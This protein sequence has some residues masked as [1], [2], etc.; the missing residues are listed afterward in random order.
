MRDEF[1]GVRRTFLCKEKPKA[2]SCSQSVQATRLA[3]ILRKD[4]IDE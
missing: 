4:R 3:P 1:R 2:K